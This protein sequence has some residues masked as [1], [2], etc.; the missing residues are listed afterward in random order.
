MPYNNNK[1][2]KILSTNRKAKFNYTL[3]KNFEAGVALLGPEVKSLR[4]YGCNIEETY[5]SKSNSGASLDL[6]N[7]YLQNY[8]S[9]SSELSPYRPR[10]LLLHKKEINY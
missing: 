6:V 10:A 8:S 1:N 3:I 2:F 9:Q 4:N 5:I 7:L